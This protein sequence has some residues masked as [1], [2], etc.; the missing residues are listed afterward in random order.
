MSVESNKPTDDTAEL[1]QRLLEQQRII[2]LQ[3]DSLEYQQDKLKQIE[4]R[5][6]RSQADVALLSKDEGTRQHAF[7]DTIA[8]QRT[9]IEVLEEQLADLQ[10]DRFGKRSEKHHNPLQAGLMLFNEA[11]V[12]LLYTSPSPRDL[13]TSRMPSSA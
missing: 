9:R 12:C 1:K 3:A 6:A 4:K 8:R 13:S 7:R 5:L 2:A 10:R 11:E